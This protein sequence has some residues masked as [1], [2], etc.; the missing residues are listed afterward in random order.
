MSLRGAAP[1]LAAVLLGLGP[2]ACLILSPGPAAQAAT[3]PSAPPSPPALAMT[4]P[5]PV[6]SQGAGGTWQ[7]T[8]L[9]TGID[10][11]CPASNTD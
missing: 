7:T 5:G 8:V 6:L 2:G 1:F 10:G 3:T 4:S 11:N 9:V